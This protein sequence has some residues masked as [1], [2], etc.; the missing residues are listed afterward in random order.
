MTPASP[1]NQALLQTIAAV[2]EELLAT[3]A[4]IGSVA[5]L[6]NEPI[7]RPHAVNL[8]S[9]SD[10]ELEQR[11]ARLLSFQ[12]SDMDPHP[13][14]H[15]VSS[16]RRRLGPLIVG[17]KRL[18][19]KLFRPI[20]GPLLTPQQNFNQMEV[21]YNLGCFIRLGQLDQRMGQLEET[22]Q[23]LEIAILAQDVQRENSR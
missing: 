20:S 11:L 8:W 1:Q 5:G 15:H 16:H 23:R 14:P 7:D 6:F 3:R 4:R 9:L 21:E 18:I 2:K 19:M 12:N 17:I 10:R 13:L 22:V